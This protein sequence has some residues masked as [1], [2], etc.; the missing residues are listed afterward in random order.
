VHRDLIPGQRSYARVDQFREP[1]SDPR[2]PQLLIEALLW[3]RFQPF[4]DGQR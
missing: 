1:A 4:G 3:F 2:S